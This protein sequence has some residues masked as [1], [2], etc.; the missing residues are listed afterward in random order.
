MISGE[1]GDRGPWRHSRLVQPHVEALP[2]A[3]LRCDF[4]SLCCC[5]KFV[6]HGSDVMPCRQA[7]LL[8]E[9]YGAVVDVQD[10]EGFTPLLR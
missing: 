8:I 1:E 2:C 3:A 9:D 5:K 7:L 10:T 6:C 4:Q